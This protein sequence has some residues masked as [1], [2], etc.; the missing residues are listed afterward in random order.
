M[1][2]LAKIAGLKG[3]DKSWN[4]QGKDLTPILSNPEN[5]VQEY[6]DFTYDDDFMTTPDPKKMGPMHIRCLME[7][8]WKYA[9][10][11][12]PYYGFTPEYEM[13]D[14]EEDPDEIKNLAYKGYSSESTEI[15]RQQLHEL[16]T[17]VMLKLGTMPDA[18]IW[19]T[20]SGVSM[21]GTKKVS[22]K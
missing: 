22:K 21:L 8:S 14:L 7:K 10:Y 5:E 11:F 19:P 6:I 4:L 20:I 3:S 17:N 18:I 12:D 13:Y 1:P 9:V 16:L 15:K 2:T